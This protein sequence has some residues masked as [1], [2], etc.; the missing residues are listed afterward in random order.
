MHAAKHLTIYILFTSASLL[1]ILPNGLF[2]ITP[3]SYTE[4]WNS[5]RSLSKDFWHFG[6]AAGSG[7]VCKKD[8]LRKR[9]GRCQSVSEGPMN[10]VL[11]SLCPSTSVS[12][13]GASSG[14]WANCLPQLESWTDRR[15]IRK[16]EA[17]SYLHN[18]LKII[19][20]GIESLSV[21]L[22]PVI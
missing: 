19:N 1:L 2:E 11:L 17:A 10:S 14:S 5:G 12:P 21:N 18:V 3:I 7:W 6:Q 15:Y 9:V 22:V 4:K 8:V 16:E 13:Q 20:R